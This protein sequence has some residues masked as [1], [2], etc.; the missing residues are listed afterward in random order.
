MSVIRS[1]P[2]DPRPTPAPRDETAHGARVL[3]YAQMLMATKGYG[4]SKAIA[5]AAEYLG[6]S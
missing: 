4:W 1:P 2:P 5:K 6:R 3:A